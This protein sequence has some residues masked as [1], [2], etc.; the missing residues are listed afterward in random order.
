MQ[1]NSFGDELFAGPALTLQQHR[2]STGSDLRYQIENLQHGLALAHNIFEVVTL[3]QCSLELDIFFFG[4]MPGDCGSHVGEQLLVIPRFLD[5][6]AG[7]GLHRPHCVLNR[8]VSRDHNHGELRV[9]SMNLDEK[10]NA[11]AVGRGQV[12][13]NKLKA[14][15]TKASKALFTATC[16]FQFVP[17][18]LE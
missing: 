18:K 15:I 12:E 17:V 16:G 3:L 10:V 13:H 7:A 9:V 6:V 14:P 4:S 11:V 8:A 2:G 1:V 5:E